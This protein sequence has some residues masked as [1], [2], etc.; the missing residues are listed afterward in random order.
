MKKSEK[1]LDAIGQI[2]DRLVEEAAKAGKNVEVSAGSKRK[3]VNRAGMYR[4]Q[5]ALAACAVL[6]VCV[7]VFGLLNR[8]G[9]IFGPLKSGSAVT[10]E[11]AMDSAANC[12][13][14]S[15]AGGALEA[16][17]EEV[18]I[19]N[20]AAAGAL[21]SGD[22]SGQGIYDEDPGS[23]GGIT[24]RSAK[25]DQ[26]EAYALEAA[27][28]EM[29]R[30][31]GIDP[32]SGDLPETNGRDDQAVKN[33]ERK[34]SGESAEKET[35]PAVTDVQQL[36]T[37]IDSAAGEVSVKVT[38][39]SVKGVTF[40]IQNK[41]DRAIHFGKAFTLER[42]TCE[43]WQEVTPQKEVV[44][45]DAETVLD[46]DGSCE[47]SVVLESCYGQLPAGQYRLVKYY[48]LA[49]GKEPQGL[50]EYPM[51]AVFTISE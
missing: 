38:E 15:A 46:T 39:S 19:L 24:G 20:E 26:P 12:A 40:V 5:G 4:W 27:E 11:A 21:G 6:A 36:Q 30:D 35:A 22:A 8:G 23:E 14:D 10:E 49:A 29:T 44:W 3:A 1:L 42:L 48:M 31:T 33:E 51:Y 25:E 9:L 17:P 7:G 2:D 43:G 28:E 34:S 37:G 13:M 32:R 16:A 41:R 50:E 45:D 47:E 18:P